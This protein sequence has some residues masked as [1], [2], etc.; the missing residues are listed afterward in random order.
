VCYYTSVSYTKHFDKNS[1]SGLHFIFIKYAERKQTEE[2]NSRRNIRTVFF[3][4]MLRNRV[5]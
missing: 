4:G 2:E 1:S 5:V 3:V